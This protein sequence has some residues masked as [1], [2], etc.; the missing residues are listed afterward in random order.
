MDPGAEKKNALFLSDK[1]RYLLD[2]LYF[3]GF[4]GHGNC[5]GARNVRLNYTRN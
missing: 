4:D 3:L 5:P 1:L 2:I